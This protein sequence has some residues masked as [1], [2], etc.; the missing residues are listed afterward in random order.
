MWQAESVEES[1]T[2]KK[3]AKG[4]QKKISVKGKRI[5]RKPG[6]LSPRPF[7]F[8]PLSVCVGFQFYIFKWIC[9]NQCFFSTHLGWGRDPRRSSGLGPF[10]L[11]Q[12]QSAFVSPCSRTCALPDLSQGYFQL[13]ASAGRKAFAGDGTAVLLPTCCPVWMM[14]AKCREGNLSF[15]LCNSWPRPTNKEKR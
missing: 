10:I 15:S 11:L 1:G 13:H 7:C 9:T 12:T 6:L 3:S 5:R 4:G 2:Q 14:E 8:L